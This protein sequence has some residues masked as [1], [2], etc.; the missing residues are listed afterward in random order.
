MVNEAAW[1]WYLAALTGL[2]LGLWPSPSAAAEEFPFD[3]VLE[4]IDSPL[5]GCKRPPTLTITGGIGFLEF[6]MCCNSMRGPARV[7]GDRIVFSLRGATV[8]NCAQEAMNG[9]DKLL[10]EFGDPKELRWRRDGDVIVIEANKTLR[11]RIPKP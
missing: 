3:I 6:Q 9:D 5:P 4:S 1:R 8:M 2:L 10:S 7:R 11:F